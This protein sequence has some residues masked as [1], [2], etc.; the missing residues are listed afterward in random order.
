V[1]A[2]PKV[3]WNVDKLVWGNLIAHNGV[4]ISPFLYLCKAHQH[5]SLSL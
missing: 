5:V 1:V 4:N 2:K 3:V